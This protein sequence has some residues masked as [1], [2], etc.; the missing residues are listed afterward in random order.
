MNFP[1]ALF[2]RPNPNKFLAALSPFMAVFL[3]LIIGGLIFAF[4]GK[5]P[6]YSMYV[7]CIEPLQ[8]LRGWGELGV[9]MTPLI[10]C[11]LGLLVCYRAN[12]WNIGAE[13]QLIVGALAGGV[14]AL[15]AGPDQSQLYMIWV[16]LAAMAGGALY[17]AIVAW[18]KD[19]CN[20]NEILVSLMLVYIAE[21]F[22]SWAVQSPLRDPQGLGFPQ[23]PMFETAASLPIMI[24]GTR[25][26]WG[27]ALVCLALFGVWLIMSKMFIGFQVRVSGMAPKAAA[28]AGFSNRAMIYFVLLLSG[29]LAGLAG[30]IEITGPIGQLTPKISPGYGFAAIIVAFVARLKP[31]NTVPAAFIMAL[32]Y[33][34]GELA[35]SRLG[36][37]AALTGVFQGLLLFCIMVCDS[38]VF[39]KFKWL[40]FS[41]K[42]EVAP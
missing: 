12:V 32:F 17:G 6:F 1:I 33:L 29:A 10:L 9:K 40:G 23:S 31:L 19:K 22:L 7:V 28:Y 2:N 3:T 11:A 8:T 35:Q 34:G 21:L 41:H 38:F 42:K 4:M 30:V 5:D 27:V 25:L 37:P 14:V 18:L 20:A 26:H 13:G 15:Q 39:F 36:T 16:L 24:P